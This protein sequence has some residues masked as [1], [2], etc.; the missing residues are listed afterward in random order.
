MKVGKE[1]DKNDVKEKEANEKEVK[2]E[3][4]LAS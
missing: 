2:V 4:T 1:V 3:D